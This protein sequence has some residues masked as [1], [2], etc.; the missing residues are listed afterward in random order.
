MKRL[1]MFAAAA[2]LGMAPATA[3]LAL[4][5]RVTAETDIG[6]GLLDA[7]DVERIGDSRRI[8]LTVIFPRTDEDPAEVTVAT[9]LIDCDQPRYR[10]ESVIAYDPEMREKGRETLTGGWQPARPE[11][12][13]VSAAGFVCRGEPLE[14]PESQELRVII[15]NYLSRVAGEQST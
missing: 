9:I 14:R 3:A 8:K 12:P 2:V 10:M 11:S 4:D 1:V 13:F 7:D 15:G 6:L 5:Y